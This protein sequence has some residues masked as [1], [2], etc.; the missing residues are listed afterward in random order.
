MTGAESD[1]A[2]A[3]GM[4]AA[5]DVMR[6]HKRSNS[7]VSAMANVLSA[8]LRE[9]SVSSVL[10]LLLLLLLLLCLNR[11]EIICLLSS[12]VSDILTKSFATFEPLELMLRAERR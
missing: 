6:R 7:S 11:V 10:P 12:N 3:G 9:L 5:A 8:A 4:F 2:V 1:G